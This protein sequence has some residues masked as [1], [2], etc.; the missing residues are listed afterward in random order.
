MSTNGITW[1]AR[2]S[3]VAMAAARVAIGFLA[4]TRPDRLAGS[5]LGAESGSRKH[6][7]VRVLGRASGGRDLMLGLGA[8]GATV[9]GNRSAGWW[10]AAGGVVDAVDGVATLA[11]W[12]DLPAESRAKF[13]I[14]AF[15][16][17]VATAAICAGL[18]G[19]RPDR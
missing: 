5:W 11:A 9:A 4:V 19:D 14:A 3:A 10:L 16:T 17:A 12:R 8:L 13:V 7:S 2:G 18:P 15:G 6:T 1:L